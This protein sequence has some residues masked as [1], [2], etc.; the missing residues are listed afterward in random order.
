MNYR[1]TDRLRRHGGFTLLELIVVIT[2]IGILATLVVVN[3]QGVGPKARLAKANSDMDTI[4]RVAIGMYNET[5][6]YPESIEEM[7]NAT[8][9][10]GMRLMM[11]LDEFPKDPWGNEYVYEI[12]D[13]GP[14]VTCLGSDGE[15]GG[16]K[17]A[18]DIQK[19][20]ATDGY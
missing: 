13:G 4:V 11:S 17:E 5:G 16:E 18:M 19:P 7:V 9:E 2:I 6:H 3:T 1:S 20:E 12:G 14:I 10:N 15:I 8:D